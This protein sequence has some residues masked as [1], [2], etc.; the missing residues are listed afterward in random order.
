M[1]EFGLDC[2]EQWKELITSHVPVKSKPPP[3]YTHLIIL[4]HIHVNERKL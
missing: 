4:M 3:T 1:L 2:Q